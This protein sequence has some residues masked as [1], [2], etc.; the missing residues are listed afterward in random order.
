MKPP[1][2]LLLVAQK[3]GPVRER[4][5]FVG[6]MIRGLLTTDPAAAPMRPTD[7]V[8]LIVPDVDS[9][10]AYHTLGAELR[11]LGFQEDASEGAPLC[12]WTVEGVTTDIMPI[13]PAV[14]GFTNVWYKSAQHH[15]VTTSADDG[16][17]SHLDA[18]HFCA[19]K[20]EAFASRA[21]GD[22]YHH[23][24]E[25]FIG[26]VDERPELVDEIAASPSEVRDFIASSTH[27]LLA[28]SEFLDALPGHLAG[29]DASQQRLPG[30]LGKLRRIAALLA[31]SAPAPRSRP[32]PK[33]TPAVARPARRGFALGPIASHSASPPRARINVDS[34]NLDWVEYDPST[35]RLIVGFLRGTE[36]AYAGVPGAVYEGLLRAYS[37]GR[38]FH[39]WVR[40]RYPTTRVR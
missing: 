21:E 34:S 3:L 20:L 10:A 29:D 13:N 12:R 33:T 39:L 23:D 22:Y 27:E 6:G 11:K 2:P 5:V 17:L 8:D 35:L 36:Y 19:T 25:D 24:I 38:Y 37:K 1:R 16:S 28:T 30:L 9:L 18:P 31:P 40:D 4:V 32:T 14:L 26:L 7:D 15:V